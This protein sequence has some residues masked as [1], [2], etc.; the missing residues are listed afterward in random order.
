M[1]QWVRW[2]IDAIIVVWFGISGWIYR[3]VM[4]YNKRLAVHE[5]F[6]KTLEL[7]LQTVEQRQTVDPLDYIKTVT[8]LTAALREVANRL[9]DVVRDLD[10]MTD[11]LDRL[12]QEQRSRN[13]V[14]G[15]RG[16]S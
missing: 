15:P 9:G 11:R 16:F 3:T 6:H 2:V 12:D 4:E 13:N 5:G 1:E 7:R 10:R 8:E 14:T